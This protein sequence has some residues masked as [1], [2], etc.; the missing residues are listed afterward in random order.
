MRFFKLIAALLMIA[1]MSVAY[2]VNIGIIGPI[3]RIGEQNTI[4]VIMK[5]LN[6]ASRSGTLKRMED[7]AIR[8][9]INSITHIKPV[10]GIVTVQTRATRLI[11]PTVTYTTSVKIGDGRIVIPAGTKINPLEITSLTKTLIFFDGRDPE[12][13][14]AVGRLLAKI[15]PHYVKPILIAGSWLD[16]TK[17]WKTQVFYDQEGT[18]VQRFG[19]TA[20]PTVIRQQGM[21]LLLEEIPAKE[22]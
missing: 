19:I 13:R 1:A 7:E 8:R 4:E 5:K 9:S 6:Q 22:L 2:T 10:E 11:D 12:Q 18:L 20:V 21:M 3:Y 16:I 17:S 14:K 15:G